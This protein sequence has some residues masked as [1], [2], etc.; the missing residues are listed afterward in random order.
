MLI[1]FEDYLQ[2]AITKLIK[3]RNLWKP[4]FEKNDVY[5]SYTLSC[6]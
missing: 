1:S 4:G 5:V 6:F 3:Y 2:I